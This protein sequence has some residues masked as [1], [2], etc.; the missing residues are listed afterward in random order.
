MSTSLL[1]AAGLATALAIA[2]S[3]LGERFL[4]SRLLR[5]EDLPR[6]RGSRSFTANT[7]RFAWHLTT[8]A[9]IGLAVIL[10]LLSRPAPGAPAT[11]SILL[12]ITLTFLASSVLSAVGGRMRHFSWWIFLAISALVTASLW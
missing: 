12:T 7:I 9:W 3:W 5:L 11:R 2:H 1:V 6:I 10:V 8:V 4:V